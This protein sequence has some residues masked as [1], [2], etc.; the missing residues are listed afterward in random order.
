LAL[1]AFYG[2]V[3]LY[4]MR[5][6]Y[7]LE[8]PQCK[9]TLRTTVSVLIAAR[10]EEKNIGL[11]L[12]DI[13][14]QNFPVHLLEI[15]VVDD[16]STDNTAVIVRSFSDQGV[17]LIQLNEKEPLNSYKKKAI[18]EAINHASGELIV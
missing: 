9:T 3:I 1:T 16:H 6:W 11:T 8:T 7:L 15:I 17:R 13:L 12:Q 14:N 18:S 4:L 10:N 2:S 5:G